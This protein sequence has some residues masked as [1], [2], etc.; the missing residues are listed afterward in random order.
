M[1]VSSSIAIAFIGVAAYAVAAG[2]VQG[3]SNA[4][5]QDTYASPADLA[6]VAR[7]LENRRAN[8]ATKRNL[9]QHVDEYR[10]RDTDRQLKLLIDELTNRLAQHSAN[11]ER[12]LDAI[13]DRIVVHDEILNSPNADQENKLLDHTGHQVRNLDQIGGGHLVRNLD[14]IGGGHLLRSLDWTRGAQLAGNFDQ[15][16]DGDFLDQIRGASLARNLDH[17]GGGHLVRNLDQIGGG[18]L[19]RSV[20]SSNV[21]QSVAQ[22]VAAVSRQMQLAQSLDRAR[23]NNRLKN[24]E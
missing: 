10:V 18:N 17:I 15:I 13:R 24:I 4:V 12:L 21:D 2:P 16:D 6:I 3:V 9:D 7:Y 19:V 20:D 22:S 5:Q 11:D 8:Q 23:S 1:A 14:Q